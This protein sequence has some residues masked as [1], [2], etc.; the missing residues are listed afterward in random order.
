[1]GKLVKLS[2]SAFVLVFF[3]G[4]GG[5]NDSND[6]KPDGNNILSKHL[7]EIFPP[8]DDSA[9][10]DALE[11][12]ARKSSYVDL[13]RGNAQSFLNQL[14]SKGFTLEPSSSGDIDSSA[15]V[16]KDIRDGYERVWAEISI[17]EYSYPDYF[18][19]FQ[20]SMQKS[21]D[22]ITIRF[23]DEYVEQIYGKVTGGGADGDYLFNLYSANMSVEV[24][25]YYQ[26][27]LASGIFD[28]GSCHKNTPEWGVSYDCYAVLEEQTSTRPAKD[29]YWEAYVEE[30]ETRLNWVRSYIVDMGG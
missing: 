15:T 21:E 1:M 9:Y 26:S 10:I 19:E 28:E 3:A 7:S 13:S 24:E 16:S 14:Y 2:L 30:E 6:S 20:M 23:S 11:K 22:N 8:F 12:S 4:C 5:G 27:L 17:S 18:V 29:L 25:N